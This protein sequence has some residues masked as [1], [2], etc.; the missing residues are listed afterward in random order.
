MQYAL[1]SYA[2]QPI[3]AQMSGI[4]SQERIGRSVV[5]RERTAATLSIPAR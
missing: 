3:L 2:L 5:V 1:I 4:P